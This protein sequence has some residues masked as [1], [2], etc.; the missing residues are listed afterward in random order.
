VDVL[1]FIEFDG[2]TKDWRD[3]GLNDDELA[4]LQI[5]IMSDPKFA[6]VVQGT[7]GLRKARFAPSRWAR[8]KRGSARVCY[9]YFEQYSLVLLV[10]AYSKKDKGNLSAQE[11]KAIRNLIAEINKELSQSLFRDE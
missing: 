1:D 4:A 8:G 7:G 5:A 3:L 2:F 11:K 9:V 6:P 10:L